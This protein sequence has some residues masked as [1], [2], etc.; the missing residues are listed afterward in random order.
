MVDDLTIV[1]HLTASRLP[2]A[3][4]TLVRQSPS[5]LPTTVLPT[6]QL[7]K[8]SVVVVQRVTINTESGPSA[9]RSKL[10]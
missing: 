9:C 2:A 7:Q 8:T 10:L 4:S 3:V 6:V 1:T 5:A